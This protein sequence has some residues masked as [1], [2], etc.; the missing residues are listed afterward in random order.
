M[1]ETTPEMLST[2]EGLSAQ[3]ELYLQGYG[4]G[5]S[6]E[7]C[8]RMAR[9]ICDLAIEQDL[10]DTREEGGFLTSEFFQEFT[11]VEAVRYATS[12]PS[13]ED[14]KLKALC[15]LT[16]YDGEESRKAL[17][18]GAWCAQNFGVRAHIGIHKTAINVEFKYAELRI[19][20]RCPDQPDQQVMIAISSQGFENYGKLEK[21]VDKTRTPEKEIIRLIGVF[22]LL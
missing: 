21:W 15:D 5:W 7:L 6:K 17:V 18:W 3:H 8:E 19:K 4:A 20:L 9:E 1:W 10:F 12:L 14:E 11:S 2:L 13:I 22:N 16:V